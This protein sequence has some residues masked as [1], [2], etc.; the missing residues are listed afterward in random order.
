[1]KYHVGVV[2]KSGEVKGKAVESKEEAEIFILEMAETIGI[3]LGR[4]RDLK[5]GLEETINF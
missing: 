5:T 1:M 3:K 2:L 4:I